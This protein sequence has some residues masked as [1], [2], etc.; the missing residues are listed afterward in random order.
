VARLGFIGIGLMGAPMTLRLLERGHGVTVWNRDPARLGAVTE[1]G[2]Q[3]AASPR[4]VAEASDVV[5]LCVLHTEAVSDCIWGPGGVAE[6]AGPRLVIDHST[7]DPAATR[8]FAQRLQ[9]K[10]GALWVDAPVSGG[11]PAARDG[12]LTIMAGADSAAWDLARPVLA[13]LGANVTRMGGVGAG[14]IAKLVNQAIVGAGFV[15]M[16]EALRLAEAAGIDAAAV[17][18][19]LA[20]GLADSALLRRIYPQM[21]RRAFDPPLSFAR[22]LLK[23]MNAVTGFAQALGLDLAIVQT[24]CAQYHAHVAAGHGMEDSAAIVRHYERPR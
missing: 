13:D 12:T 9:A 8:D 20:G 17:P 11:P 16:A 14:Q 3:P 22:Q 5:L 21:Q 1:A 15:L 10:T 6:V 19:C 23:D 2:A 7:I 24:A 18:E 4:E